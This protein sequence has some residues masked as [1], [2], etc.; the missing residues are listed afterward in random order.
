M[1]KIVKVGVLICCFIAIGSI[2][3]LRYLQFQKKEAEEREWEICIAYRRQNDAL[4]RK[5]GPLHLYEYS[6]YEHIDEKELFVALHVYNMSDRCKEKVT[7]E[8]VKKY[9]S[10]E[11]DEEGNLYVLNKNNKVHDYIEWYRKRVITD[12]GMDFV[13]EHQ[14]ER[15]WTRLSEIVLNYVREGNDF[16]NQDVKSFSYEKLK[17]IMKKADDPSY[18]INDDIMKKPINEAE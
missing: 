9:L 16:P 2:L 15:Y 7:L 17:E 12:T 5:D 14:I 13:G 11:F 4:I 3:Y 10:S 18:Q 1:K 6:S 8:D